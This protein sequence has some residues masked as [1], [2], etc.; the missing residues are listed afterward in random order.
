MRIFLCLIPLMLA[1]CATTHSGPKAQSSRKDIV[2]SVERNNDLSDKYYLFLEFTI[3]NTTPEWKEVQITDVNIANNSSEILTGEKLEAWIEGAELKMKQTEYNKNLLLGS[4]IAVG[5]V[6]T[7]SAQN[8]PK[9][10]TTGAIGAGTA[11]TTMAINSTARAHSN[12]T[13]GIRG[14]NGTVNVPKTHIFVPSK[15]AP[16]SYIRRWIVIQAPKA[17]TH[18]NDDGS[19]KGGEGFFYQI[20]LLS[21]VR[22]DK[23]APVTYT[24]PL[25]LRRDNF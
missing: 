17:E 22:V 3:E 25:K 12:A 23:N 4:L 14:E 20:E 10:A 6:T 21:K 13:S 5:G 2:M 18:K 11:A 19:P 24:S 16:E 15:I 7:I 8:N 9:L 1:A